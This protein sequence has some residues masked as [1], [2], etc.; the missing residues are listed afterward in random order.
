MA[1]ES[2]ILHETSA[3]VRRFAALCLLGLAPGAAGAA[4]ALFDDDAVLDVRLAGPL[5]TLSGDRADAVREEHPFTLLVAGSDIPLSV[6]VRGKSRIELC[7]FPP[8][9]LRF[10]AAHAADTVFAG[11]HKLK[12]VTHCRSDKAHFENNLLDEYTAYRIFNLLSETSYRA[13]L[14]RIAYED[15]DGKLKHLDRPYYGFL[16]ESD[17][18]LADRLGASVVELPGILYSRLNTT[19]TTRMAVFQYLIGNTDWSFVASAGEETCC[20]NVDLLEKDDELYP[21]P[22]DFDLSGLVNATYAKPAAGVRARKVTQRVYRGYCRSALQD[23][24]AALEDVVS[25][26]DEI[27]SISASA[28]VVGKDSAVARAQY[29]DRFFEEAVDEREK[30]L[31]RFERDCV[32]RD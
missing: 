3:L 10:A 21:V 29:I 12:L 9:R 31:K 7:D 6:R 28:P 23:V 24:A 20:H 8:L 17:D 22:F 19:Q 18:G 16:I 27:I 14:L 15:T 4:A 26:R 13:R 25:L 1:V 11:Q 2:G 30:L 32:G 5:A